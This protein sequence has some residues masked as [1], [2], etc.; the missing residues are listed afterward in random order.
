MSRNI[1]PATLHQPHYPM[2]LL[3]RWLSAA[4]RHNAVL[5]L[6][7]VC[8]GVTVIGAMVIRDM[9]SANSEAQRMYKS[10][11]DGLEEIGELQY[12]AQE[13]RRTTLYALTTTDSNLQVEYADQTREAD[14]RVRN[15]IAEYARQAK[16]PEEQ[17]L[18]DRLN[19]DWT[20]YLNVRDE[21]LA[22]ILE[23][24]TTE[25]VSLD[26]A[27]GVPAFER[28]RQDLNEV[29]RLFGEDASREQAS[30]AESSRRS[31]SRIVGI[32]SFTFLLSA[33]AIWAIQRSQMLGRMQLAKLQMEFVA[34]VSHELRTPLAV[35]RSA[36]DNIADGLVKNKESLIRYGTVLQH[37]SRS[38]GELVDQILLFASTEDRKR[39]VVLQP[40]AVE[41]IMDV[42][43]ADTE[44]LIRESGFTLELETEPNLPVVMA[45]LPG[46]TQCLRNLVGN[47]VKYGGA[48]HKVTLRV[49]TSPGGDKSP[50]EVRI[51]VSD[52]GIG[53][54]SSEIGR[55]FEPFYRS[56]RV[57][58]SQ[59]HGTGLGLALARRLAESM[60]GSLSVHSQ[61]AVGSTFTLHLPLA[62]GEDLQPAVDEG[63]PS[64]MSIT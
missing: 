43:L 15:G 51:A 38:M 24:S 53:I 57:H 45:D 36:A 20:A 30:L 17:A 34:S 39:R 29:K 9:Q 12:D 63:R 49:S 31:S 5:L 10:S 58:A 6:F 23:G 41:R 21:V 52:R 3:D 47:A 26:L 42:V 48:D 4:S 59:I 14:R 22:S 33:A 16:G 32:L 25:A 44:A 54:D 8:C 64:R 37:Q 28:V 61:V 18:A 35:I 27:G 2:E 55:I 60:G 62:Q 56:P 13:T 50:G 1:K 40:L 11:V 7:V 19:R 46:I